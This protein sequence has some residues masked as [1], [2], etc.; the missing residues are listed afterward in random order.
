MSFA[1]SLSDGQRKRYRRIAV[2]STIFG[3][4]STQ[5]IENNAPI[6][7]YLAM[8]G[9]ND[10]TSMFSTSLSGL[11]SLLLLI[12]SA[13]LC[14]WLGLRKTYTLS[15]LLG[16]L[17]FMTIASAPLFG[18]FA[19]K[20]VIFGVFMYGISI[21][22]YQSTW[23]P[24][25]DNILRSEDRGSFFTRMR[26]TYMIIMALLLYGLGKFLQ[27]SPEKWLLQGI[28]M[29]AGLTLWGRKFCMDKIPVSPDMQRETPDIRKSLS[30]C[31]HNQS[32]TGY[33][34][35]LCFFYIAYAAAIPLALVYM[36]TSLFM[37]AGTIMILTSVNM[38]GK[39]FGFFILGKIGKYLTTGQQTV[40]NHITALIAIILLLAAVPSA[41]GLPFIFGTAF[42]LLGIVY[43]LVN[44]TAAVE[45][46]SLARPGNKIMAIAFCMTAISIGT[47]AG[48]LLSTGLIACGA[49]NENWQFMGIEMTKFQILFGMCALLMF[50]I[51]TLFPLVPAVIGKRDDYY[52][53]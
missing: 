4:F 6:V 23:Y 38:A 3:C 32:L 43:A 20:S 9:A 40:I 44:C 15:S 17:A 49:L 48:T 2:C 7:L 34:T 28:F 30:I 35:Y 19:C 47:A 52:Q 12:P 5:I 18:Q 33:A 37:A 10:S 8:L 41:K 51:I 21:T 46:L 36:K 14:A 16:F 31:L 29:L 24:L 11:A 22:I 53:P 45:M 50:F 1:D 13:S 25:L 26:F 39:I 42:F 27:S